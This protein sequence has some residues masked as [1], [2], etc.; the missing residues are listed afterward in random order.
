MDTNSFQR[1]L[2]FLKENVAVKNDNRLI[3]SSFWWLRHQTTVYNT[4][5]ISTMYQENTTVIYQSHVH[6]YYRHSIPLYD[7]L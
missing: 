5:I 4:Q 7:T 1:V 3:D 2:F 6:N